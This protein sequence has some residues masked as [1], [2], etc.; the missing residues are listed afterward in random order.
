MYIIITYETSGVSSNYFIHMYF[1]IYFYK[2]NVLCQNNK[3][4]SLTLQ[5]QGIKSPIYS[6]MWEQNLNIFKYYSSKLQTAF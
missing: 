4:G 5:S 2:H 3:F 1:K 6:I